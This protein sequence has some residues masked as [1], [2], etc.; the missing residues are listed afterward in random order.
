MKKAP[1]YFVVCDDLKDLVSD[2]I[3]KGLADDQNFPMAKQTSA[4]DWEVSFTGAE[5]VSIAMSDIDYEIIYNEL[6]EKRSF[7]VKLI[8]GGLIQLMYRFKGAALVK[9]RLTYYPSP[10]LRPFH[11]D[12]DSYLRDEIFLEI[13]SRR[14]IPFPLR[15]DF[16]IEAAKDILHPSCHLTL[17]DVKGCRIPVAA[18]LT[19]RQF[20]EFIVRNFYQTEKHD[21][22]S[23]FPNH[24]LHFEP[25]ITARERGLVHVAIPGPQ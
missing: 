1:P 13:V 9:H 2:L 5:H 18:P 11:D 3:G 8:D 22:V 7:S 20:V 6:V 21:F 4:Q 25:S 12:P 14:I 24:R 19:P 10:S 15:F 23:T 17:G 16:D